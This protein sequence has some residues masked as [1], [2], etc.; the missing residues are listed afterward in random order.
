ML[1]RFTW[2]RQSAFQWKDDG[3]VVYIDP[4]GVTTED[5]ADVIFI[6]HAHED[7]LQPDEIERLRKDGTAIV[8]PADIAS[9][10]SGD[11]TAVKPGDSIEVAGI[12]VQAVHA[13]NVVEERL[14][15]HPKSN[16]WVGYV[17]TLGANTYYHAGDTD[18]APELSD[19]RADV[20]FLPIGGTYTMDAGEAAGLAKAI[21]P[22]LAVPMHYGFVVGSPSDAELFAKEADPVPVQ[23]LTPT[24]PFER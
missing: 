18:H 9:G 24:N 15:M 6:T 21:S 5:P 12:K 23:T 19:V 17:L 11:V 4:W 10:L 8:A 20:A 14:Q 22:K 16:N 3:P 1:D 13:Y 2:F 7:H